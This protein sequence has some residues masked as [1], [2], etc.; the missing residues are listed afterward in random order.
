MQLKDSRRHAFRKAV[1]VGQG[2]TQDVGSSMEHDP[3]Y[4]ESIYGKGFFTAGWTMDRGFDQ[5][6]AAGVGRS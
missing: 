2:G 6:E 4:A 5:A 1:P 3:K